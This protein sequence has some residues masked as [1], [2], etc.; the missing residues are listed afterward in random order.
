MVESFQSQLVHV[1]VVRVRIQRSV[2]DDSSGH[3][4]EYPR[5]TADGREGPTNVET[6]GKLRNRGRV[7]DPFV[8]NLGPSSQIGC[9][10]ETSIGSFGMT[11]SARAYRIVQYG[12]EKQI[13]EALEAELWIRIR[14]V[15]HR[16]SLV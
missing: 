5:S 10:F 2:G 16:T 6:V 1:D 11:I 4:Q 8:L 14:R 9:R 7:H 3:P 13:L 12:N 15:V